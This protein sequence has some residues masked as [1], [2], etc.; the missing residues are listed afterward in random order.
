[1]WGGPSG[2]PLLVKG[3]LMGIKD[4]EADVSIML[5]SLMVDFRKFNIAVK[6]R[7]VQFSVEDFGLIICC[8]ERL[9]YIQIKDL[10]LSKF[11][12]WRF[13]FITVGDNMLTKK[14]EVIWELMRCG[15]MKWLRYNYPRQIKNILTG[16][17]NLGQR[18]IEERLRV[19]ADRPK[20][21]F[22]IEDNKVAMKNGIQRELTNDPSFF[23]YMPEEEINT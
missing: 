5:R 4:L 22:L 12:G 17:E 11:K 13:C 7:S 20:Y 2:P 21:K 18:I 1:M 14:Y 6:D 10:M 3:K 23:D 15:Y 8:I 16:P 19:W 9:D